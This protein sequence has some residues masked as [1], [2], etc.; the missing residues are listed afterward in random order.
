ML[1][2]PPGPEET[3]LPFKGSTLVLLAATREEAVAVLKADPYTE[4]NV[5]DW[6]RAEIYAVSPQKS[7]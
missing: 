6:E 2:H 5:W 3:P 1:A 7:F 4:G